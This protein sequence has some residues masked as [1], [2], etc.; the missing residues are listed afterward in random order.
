[1]GGDR[2][3]GRLIPDRVV[4]QLG[5]VVGQRRDVHAAI[6]RLLH[7]DVRAQ[8]G[9]GGIVE[10]KVAAASI[11]ECLHRLP[12]CAGNIGVDRVA[13]RIEFRVDRSRLKPKVHY[14]RR[15]NAHLRHHLGI[16][17][18]EFEGSSIG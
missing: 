6:L 11:V 15:R 14:R 16:R 4:D 3:V 7:L 12:V 8:I 1:M 2:H 13:L 9:P 18:Q 10:L 5:V 17:F